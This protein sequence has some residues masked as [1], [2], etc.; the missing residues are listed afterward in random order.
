MGA[1]PPAA[2]ARSVE[3]SR[4]SS[5]RWSRRRPWLAEASAAVAS[6]PNRRS[7]PFKRHCAGRS[8]ARAC[9]DPPGTGRRAAWGRWR[10]CPLVGRDL[11][12]A[13]SAAVS[14]PSLRR[15]HK[16]RQPSAPNLRP[17]PLQRHLTARSA[18]EPTFP[19]PQHL[20]RAPRAMPGRQKTAGRPAHRVR[21]MKQ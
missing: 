7:L 12:A 20:P 16:G 21:A 15:R 5:R 9:A 1:R 3:T 6:A 17:L 11:Q 19:R 8:T 10:H 4:R 13:S 2:A 18:T 14:T